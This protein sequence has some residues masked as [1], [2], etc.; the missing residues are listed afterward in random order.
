M[1]TQRCE[2]YHL[3]PAF[4]IG[5]GTG[6]WEQC[7]NTATHIVSFTRKEGGSVKGKTLP[8]CDACLQQ[9]MAGEDKTNPT[10]L[11]TKRIRQRK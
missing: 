1:A 5:G 7:I 11:K 2:G 9:L 10:V 6:R 8:A 3:R 4:G